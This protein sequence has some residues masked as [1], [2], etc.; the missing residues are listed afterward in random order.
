M[1]K[2]RNSRKLKRVSLESWR[3]GYNVVMIEDGRGD[4][5]ESAEGIIRDEPSCSRAR[6]MRFILESADRHADELK[7]M[8]NRAN[9]RWEDGYSQ[10]H[11]N[12][13]Q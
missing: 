4:W 8:S 13:Y 2:S 7:R 3:Q 1:E 6:A 9:C 10:C 5:S 12:R 11:S